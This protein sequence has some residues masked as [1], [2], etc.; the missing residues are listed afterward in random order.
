MSSGND[1]LTDFF[2]VW[3]S[4]DMVLYGIM[5]LLMARR[6][7]MKFVVAEFPVSNQILCCLPISINTLFISEK[8]TIIHSSFHIMFILKETKIE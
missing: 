6:M 8:F 7:F 1:T 2:W 5:K 4:L 3:I